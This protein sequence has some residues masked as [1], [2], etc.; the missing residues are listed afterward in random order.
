[1]SA[2]GPGIDPREKLDEAVIAPAPTRR[3]RARRFQYFVLGAT[4]GF[5]ALAVVARS[6]PYFPID[7]KLTRA[8]QADKGIL[9]AQLMAGVSWLGYWPQV[10]V[11][12]S[13]IVLSLYLLGLRWEAVALSSTAFASGVGALVKL[14]VMRPR[15]T[16]DLVEVSRIL[17]TM[18][19]PSGHVVTATAF[20]GFLVF[21]AYSLLK[22]SWGRT[23]LIGCLVLEIL[24]MGVSRM[25]LGNHWFSDVV[26]GHVLGGL[27]LALSI[28]FYRWG[29]TRFFV[30][31]P[32]ASSEVKAGKT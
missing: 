27:W 32:V 26:G 23:L 6:V 18:S 1:M 11:I 3:R 7:L 29:K 15:P 16:A 12:G 25:F 8:L 21:L 9:F 17:D 30:H 19:F 4:L 13:A 31:Q 5:I 10:E 28:Q 20:G 14:A 22:P 24:L 2:D